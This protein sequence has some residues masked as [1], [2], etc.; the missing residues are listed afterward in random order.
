MVKIRETESVMVA[1]GA[2]EGDGGV[3]L[4]SLF[5]EIKRVMGVDDGGGRMTMW[6]CLILPNE[7]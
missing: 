3:L 5:Y 2:G 1:A 7:H 4:N 6:L